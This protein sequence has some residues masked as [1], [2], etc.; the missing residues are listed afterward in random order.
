[1]PKTTALTA[2]CTYRV[3][4]GKEKEMLRLLGQQWATLHR[5]GLIVGDR[6][7]R[8]RGFRQR[9]NHFRPAIDERTIVEIVS[10]KS[11]RASELAHRNP[12]VLAIWEPMALCCE[13]ME[14]PNF[15]ALEN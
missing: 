2:V 8:L 13:S 12:E 5:H 11:A 6:P 9:A 15:V 7:I 1:M 3:K 14:F 10:W 4:P